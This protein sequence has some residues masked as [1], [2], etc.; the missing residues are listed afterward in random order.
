MKTIKIDFVDFWSGFEKEN[1]FFYN[2]LKK[3]YQ[4]EISDQPDYIFAS[5][6]GDKHLQYQN[7]IKILY[8]GE[9]IIPDFNLFDYAMGFHFIDFE[10]RYVRLPLYVLYEYQVEK[11]L[12]KHTFSDEYYLAKKG[13]C[14]CV[15]SNPYAAGE[16]NAMIDTLNTYK[17]VDSGGRYRN[18]VGGPVE[19]KIE[20]SKKYRFSM[21]FENSR[22]NGY[23]TEKIFEAFAA[24]TIPIYWGSPKVALDFNPDSFINCHDY[25]NFEEALEVIKSVYEDDEKYLRMIKAPILREDSLAKEYLKPDYL[26]PFL[27]NIF[28]QEKEEAYRRNMVYIGDDYQKK[29]RKAKRISAGL[30][31]I[32]KP[33]HLLNKK[34]AQIASK[35]KKED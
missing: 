26:D 19:D 4:V 1:N 23:T 11:A 20:F 33:V 17:T 9:N 6:F 5:C 18:N 14:N 29:M 15:I 31:V 3:Y 8:L 7:C 2:I 12:K 32:K 22:M 16:R 35:M 34:K 27:K 10:D 13:F 21:A 30:D 25:A 28:D 24:D